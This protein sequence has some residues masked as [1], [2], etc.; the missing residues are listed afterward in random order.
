MD[1]HLSSGLL[2]LDKTSAGARVHD[3]A[4]GLGDLVAGVFRKSQ[5]KLYNLAEREEMKLTKK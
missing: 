4:G 2:A 5:P 3:P 1:S